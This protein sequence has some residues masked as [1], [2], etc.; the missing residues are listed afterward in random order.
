M[1]GQD[2]AEDYFFHGRVSSCKTIIHIQKSKKKMEST[3]E[4]HQE[5]LIMGKFEPRSWEK[6]N[7][8]RF[9]DIFKR[10]SGCEERRYSG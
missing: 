9:G 10:A 3:V 5:A 8:E 2:F 1:I 4:L 7:G 6:T